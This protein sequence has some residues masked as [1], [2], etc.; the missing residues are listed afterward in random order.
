MSPL[1]WSTAVGVGLWL[2][3]RNWPFAFAAVGWGVGLAMRDEVAMAAGLIASLG[4][5]ALGQAERYEKRRDADEFQSLVFL[6]RLRQLWR[7]RGT[8]AG[9]L[10]EMGYRSRRGTR[11]AAEEVLSDIANHFQVR[12]LVLVSKVASIVRRHGGN[13][14]PLLAWGAGSIQEGQARRYVRQ[15]E[16]QA[17]RATVRILAL[18]PVGVVAVFRFFIPSFYRALH[19]TWMGHTALLVVGVSTG[20][21]TWILAIQVR[22][23]ARE[24]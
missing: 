22:K 12:S 8:L 17:R 20:V 7:V 13:L 6:E 2:W 1:A 16:E 14:E 18:A 10:D 24:R 4:F 19:N 11:D 9:A 23:E 3:L 15:T 5:T 21:V